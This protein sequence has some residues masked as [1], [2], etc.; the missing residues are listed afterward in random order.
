[1]IISPQT[2]W[3]VVLVWAPAALSSDPRFRFPFG[4][5]KH[6][7]LPFGLANSTVMRKKLNVSRPWYQKRRWKAFL[8][9]FCL[10]CTCGICGASLVSGC[11]SASSLSVRSSLGITTTALLYSA[12][13]E[14]RRK[15]G[16]ACVLNKTFYFQLRTL[17]CGMS[18]YVKGLNT[19]F[20]FSS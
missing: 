2:W 7:V 14:A 6:P 13:A 12:K 9:H 3:A 18:T 5:L 19:S 15:F 10:A 8:S 16:G 20:H 4:P 1:M 17:Q 11:C